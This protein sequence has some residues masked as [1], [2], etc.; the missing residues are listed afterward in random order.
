MFRA[1][2]PFDS[3]TD[4]GYIIAISY[5]AINSMHFLANI[6]FMTVFGVMVINQ[7]TLHTHILLAKLKNLGMDRSKLRNNHRFQMEMRNKVGELVRDHQNI[8][9]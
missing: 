3:T 7:V 1:V 4:S 9:E 6:C 5:Q 8:I 2:F